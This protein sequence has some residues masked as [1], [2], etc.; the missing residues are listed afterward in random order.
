MTD[1]M[2]GCEALWDMPLVKSSAEE[3]EMV[4]AEGVELVRPLF[5]ASVEHTGSGAGAGAGTAVGSAS[6]SVEY[7]A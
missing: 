7:M 3:E 1:G 5:G 6:D 4:A 2:L